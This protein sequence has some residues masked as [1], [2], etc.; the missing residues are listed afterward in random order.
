MRILEVEAH[1][2][3]LPPFLALSVSYYLFSFYDTFFAEGFF[4]IFFLFVPS[5]QNG[6]HYY[7]LRHRLR[8]FASCAP[9]GKQEYYPQHCL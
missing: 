7:H 4:G 3:P 5:P 1:P 6:H 9:R 2:E 8:H